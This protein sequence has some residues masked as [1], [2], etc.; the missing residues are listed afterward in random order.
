[1]LMWWKTSRASA[2]DLVGEGGREVGLEPEQAWV[3]QASFY[4][5]PTPMLMVLTNS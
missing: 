3:E 4:E 5:E 1:V 2:S